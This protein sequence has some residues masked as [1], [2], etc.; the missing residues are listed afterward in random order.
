MDVDQRECQHS[1]SS[2]GLQAVPGF[3]VYTCQKCG[4]EEADV[5][6]PSIGHFGG[7]AAWAEDNRRFELQAETE[8]LFE[9]HMSEQSPTFVSELMQALE[10]S[11][12]PNVRCLREQ[13][14]REILNILVKMRP[15]FSPPPTKVLVDEFCA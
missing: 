5:W 1:W 2:D 4:K 10:S 6:N 7:S 12:F 9:T 11:D 3:V 13:D 8:T 14:A 15:A